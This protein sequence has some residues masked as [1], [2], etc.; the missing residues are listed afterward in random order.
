[1]AYPLFLLILNFPLQSQLVSIISRTEGELSAGFGISL[2]FFFEALF[3][4]L[5]LL[6]AFPYL[7]KSISISL[8]LIC[9]LVTYAMYSYGT[10]FDY[11]KIQNVFETNHGEATVYLNLS[12]AAAFL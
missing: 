10:L 4:F 8:V 3:F 9:S 6:C 2:P 7:L 11:S 12:V 1:V 5:F